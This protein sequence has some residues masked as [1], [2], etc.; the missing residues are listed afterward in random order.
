MSYIKGTYCHHVGY[1]IKSEIMS[2]I[3][4]EIMS[5]IKCDIMSYIKGNTLSYIKGT[6]CLLFSVKQTCDIKKNLIIVIIKGS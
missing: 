4:S 2:Y 1:N 6:Y 3:K 5:Y